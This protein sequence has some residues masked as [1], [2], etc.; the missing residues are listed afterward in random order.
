MLV[1]SEQDDSFPQLS[2]AGCECGYGNTIQQEDGTLV[3]VYCYANASEIV[4]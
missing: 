2:A 1:L 4:K 3:T